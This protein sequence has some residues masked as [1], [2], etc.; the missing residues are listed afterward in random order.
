MFFELFE[1]EVCPQ[2]ALAKFGVSTV[3]NVLQKS[4]AIL[5][6]KTSK[7]NQIY[8]GIPTSTPHSPQPVLQHLKR[9]K[10]V[11]PATHNNM[12]LDVLPSSYLTWTSLQARRQGQA[13]A[14]WAKAQ[15]AFKMPM[16]LRPVHQTNSLSIFTNLAPGKVP[17]CP[18][19]MKMKDFEFW[20]SPNLAHRSEILTYN[21][22]SQND[23]NVND[24]VER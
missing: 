20:A 19:S 2:I 23:Q 4:L 15:P 14:A 5:M 16:V 10:R 1:M 13:C 18:R 21:T 24:T 7:F 3:Q 9:V 22:T 11:N 17:L 6:L 12:D 8:P